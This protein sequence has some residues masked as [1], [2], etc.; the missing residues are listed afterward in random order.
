MGL[1]LA[2]VG[3]LVAGVMPGLRDALADPDVS[4]LSPLASW[5]SDRRYALAGGLLFGF[6]LGLPVGLLGG[7][8][9]GIAAGLLPGLAYGLLFGLA[10]GLVAGLGFG[11]VNSHTWS[12]SLASAQL[13]MRWRTPVRL[14]RFLENACERGVLRTVGP[15]YQFRHARLQDR[16]IGQGGDPEGSNTISLG[17]PTSRSAARLHGVQPGR[18]ELS[19]V[20]G[21]QY[22]S[23]I[24][25]VIEQR[26][27]ALRKV[28][29]TR[30]RARWLIWTGLLDF[31]VGFGLLAAADLRFIKAISDA[32]QNGNETP[33]TESPFGLLGWAVAAI[34]IL[35][36]VIGIVLHI[37]AIARRRRIDRD[38]PVP[39]P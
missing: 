1:V 8:I 2:I 39:Q 16:L 35:L 30:T 23:N 33:P 13:A 24:Q 6:G 9:A 19:S 22:S 28:A 21:D 11:L 12:S 4:S 27:K 31:V 36:L 37:I 7:L 25:H 5:R 18:R 32:V 3:G 38:L 14:M 29:A 17:T 10:I 26:E 15:V 20:S 34:G